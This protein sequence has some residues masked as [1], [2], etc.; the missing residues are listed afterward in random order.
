MRWLRRALAAAAVLALLAGGTGWLLLAGSLPQLDGRIAA[1][2]L[3]APVTVSRDARGVATIEAKNRRDLAWATGF[4]HAQERYFQMDLLRRVAAGELAE[5]V[6]PAAIEVDIKHRRHRFRALAERVYAALP[7][8]ERALADAYRDGVNAGLAALDVRPW[9]YLLLRAR[10]QRWRSEDSL[11]VIEAMFLDLNSDGYDERDLRLAQMRAALPQPVLALLTAREGLWEAPL[12]GAASPP[13]S[14]PGPEVFDLRRTALGPLPDTARIAAT[15]APAEA[16]PGSNNFAV[17][18]ALTATGA[19]IVANDM[20]LTLRVPDIWFRARLRYPDASAPG[21]VRDL[22]GVTL[23]GVPALV[24][25]SNGRIAWAFTNSY[26][27]WEDWVRVLRD[28]A[29]PQRYRVPEG[30]ARIERHDE[31]IRVRGAAPRTVAVEDTRWGPILAHDVDGTPLALAWTAQLPR[32]LNLSLMRLEQAADADAALAMAPS[33]G[34]PAQNFV[35]GDARGHIGWTLTG[36]ALPLRAG[37]DPDFPADWSRPGT[38]WTGFAAAA[39]Y[40]R[41]ENPADGR[42][43][44]ANNRTTSDAWLALLGDSG[45]DNGARAQQIRDDLRARSHFAPAD[46]LAIQLDDRALFLARWQ[47]LLQD[48]LAGSEEP[49]LVELRRLTARWRGRATVDSV[50]YRLVRA[51]R[52]EVERQVLAPFVARVQA[53]FP[54]FELPRELD[55]EAAVWALVT[56]QPPYLL[57]PRYPDWHAL[58]TSSARAVAERLGA[59]PGGLAA[60]TWGERNTAAIRHPLSAALPGFLSRFL[61]M[62]REPLPGDRDMPRVQAPAF[63]A[64]ERFGIMPGHE[65]LSYLHMPGGQ[66]GHPLSPFH[67]AGHE[68]WV[69]GVPTPLLPGPARHRMTLQPAVAR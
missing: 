53:R 41:I 64:S 35:V 26:G 59:E 12:Q 62:P 36:N 8:D 68:D 60:R 40:P 55:R 34:M 24:A 20:H 69:R 66:S 46:L 67:G 3:Q 57:D 65:D 21:G 58:L 39:Q 17:A 19:A 22:N 56:Q 43:W 25:G 28:P 4:V 16:R 31:V 27:D 61:D 49:A 6:G 23:P 42:L 50:D 5:L 2:G 54:D 48:T 1:P 51:F 44:T 30:W 32:A 9:E 38:G 14:I 18:G 52:D 63:G 29:D 47:R 33:F 7:P 45:Y 15:L 37:Y 11:L 13:P 10:P